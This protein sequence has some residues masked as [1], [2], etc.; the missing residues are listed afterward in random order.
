MASYSNYTCAN[1]GIKRPAYDMKQ[2]YVEE[3]SGKSGYSVS[4][5]PMAGQGKV[6]KSARIHSGRT[7]TSN[8]KIRLC[9]TIDACHNLKYFDNLRAEQREQEAFNA[10]K[11]YLQEQ[12]P[13]FIDKIPP[14]SFDSYFTNAYPKTE[15]LLSNIK[16]D[17]K[18]FIRKLK[19]ILKEN[20]LA[21]HKLSFS[22]SSITHETIGKENDGILKYDLKQIL[23][24]FEKD[25][26]ID[27]KT[28]KSHE[29]KSFKPTEEDLE[30]DLFLETVLSPLQYGWAILTI[31]FGAISFWWYKILGWFGVEISQFSLI[32]I[33]VFSLLTGGFFWWNFRNVKLSEPFMAVVYDDKKNRF[34]TAN[35]EEQFD[36]IESTIQKAFGEYY[37]LCVIYYL[38]DTKSLDYNIDLYTKDIHNQA[39]KCEFRGKYLHEVCSHVLGDDY[40]DLIKPRLAD[41]LSLKRSPTIEAARNSVAGNETDGHTKT[42]KGAAAG[43]KPVSCSMCNGVGQV[44]AQQGSVTNKI[45][46][47]GSKMLDDD[48]A[49]ELEKF[50]KKTCPACSGKGSV[51]SS[52]CVDNNT[53]KEHIKWK[54]SDYIN[55]FSEDNFLEIVTVILGVKVAEALNGIEESETEALESFGLND[56]LKILESYPKSQPS[57]MLLCS[58]LKKKYEEDILINIINNLFCI[59][60]ADGDINNKE[61]AIIRR[62]SNNMGIPKEKFEIIT[63]NKL[64]E[65]KQEKNR[66][67]MHDDHSYEEQNFD[68]I[69]FDDIDDVDF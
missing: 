8:K 47:I 28:F 18:E 29:F 5:S 21:Y 14:V 66:K 57:Y 39:K 12:A 17:F 59:A 6:A 68:D 13:L 65:K 43:S 27:K 2:E 53:S 49:E 16:I 10:Y 33:A 9:A 1:C 4:F 63:E 55:L 30:K 45:L 51:I 61:I 31:L 42:K 36:S 41:F 46:N 64:E 50:K 11:L 69:D 25:L 62:L 23:Q 20:Q 19:P 3:V 7:Y 58:F 44:R 37:L 48:Q 60:E 24:Q 22:K 67:P 26:T 15:N 38:N 56:M 32:H 54:K 40:E 52:P 34:I 35:F